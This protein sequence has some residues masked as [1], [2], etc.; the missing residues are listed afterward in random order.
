MQA[1]NGSAAPA[2]TIGNE[3]I[4]TSNNVEVDAKRAAIDDQAD[5]IWQ[6]LAAAGTTVGIRLLRASA[7]PFHEAVAEG[8]GFSVG[9]RSV[10]GF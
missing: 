2:P 8:Q 4:E 6:H 10:S 5:T 7:M 3:A 9:P 1:S